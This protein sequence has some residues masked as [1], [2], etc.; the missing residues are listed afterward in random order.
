MS[1]IVQAINTMI[2]NKK[3]ITNIIAGQQEIFFVYRAKYIWSMRQEPSRRDYSLWYYPNANNVE[4]LAAYDG[5]DWEFVPMVVY[6]TSEIGTK[7]ALSSFTELYNLLKER[8]HNVDEVLD[9]IIS[10]SDEF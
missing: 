3:Q 4:L 8:M 2:S 7:E 1:K 6:K 10:N 9:D 5:D